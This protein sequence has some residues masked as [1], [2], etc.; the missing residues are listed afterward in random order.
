MQLIST[1]N[2]QVHGWI[3]L[4]MRDGG[5]NA[6]YLSLVADELPSVLPAACTSSQAEPVAEG[7]AAGG[8]FFVF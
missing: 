8:A 3:T 4:V 5:E 6:R 2:W 7:R 1:L